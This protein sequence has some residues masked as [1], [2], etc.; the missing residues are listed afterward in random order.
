[1]STT[2][3]RRRELR[4]G[5][6]G[7]HAR[8]RALAA[9]LSVVALTLGAPGAA[10]IGAT[11]LAGPAAAATGPTL[12]NVAQLAE[13]P[14][15]GGT[16]SDQKCPTGDVMVGLSGQT[17]KAV[18]NTI[19]ITD[20][21]TSC[22]PM[23]VSGGAVAPG[24]P[25]MQVGPAIGAAGNNGNFNAVCPSPKV[26]VGFEVWSDSSGS[27]AGVHGYQISC[28]AL[29]ATGVPVG[30][31][32]TV[33]AGVQ[34]GTDSTAQMCPPVSGAGAP[35]GVGA[36]YAGA[37][38]SNGR[39]AG[40]S[41]WCGVIQV[42][43]DAPVLAAIVP[44]SPGNVTTPSVKGTAPAGTTVSVYTN[45]T[46]A[47]TA[48]A[49]GSAS[50]LSTGIA[51]TVPANATTALSAKATANGVD[52]VC[53][54]SL[55]YLE[56]SVAPSISGAPTTAPN[57]AGWYHSDVAIHWTCSDSGSGVATCPTNSTITGEGSNLSTVGTTT[58]NAGNS[59]SS[60]VSGIKID[61]TPPTT[62]ATIAG[63]EPSGWYNTLPLS[64]TLSGT[65]NLSGVSEIQYSLDGVAGAISGSGG[66]VEISSSGHHTLSMSA[67]D[68]AGNVEASHQVSIDVDTDAPA[69]AASLDPAPVGVWNRT[70]VTVSM[71]CADHALADG[72]AG[73]GVATC[74]LGASSTTTDNLD[75]SKTSSTSITDEGRFGLAGSAS[76][77]AGNTSSLSVTANVDMTPPVVM[78]APTGTIG[79]NG[80]YTAPVTVSFSCADP[81]L[82]DQS[83]GS[84]VV[85]CPTAVTLNNDGK[86]QQATSG[87]S[88]DLA[89]N[90]S[91]SSLDGI[92]IDQTGPTVAVTYNGSAT[93]QGWYNGPVTVHFACAD[94]TSGVAGCPDDVTFTS[95][96][97][98]HSASVVAT[99]NAGNET[100]VTVNGVNIDL[101]A[102]SISG[103]ATPAPNGNG[104]NN[105][106]V[107]INWTCLDP[108]LQDGADGSGLSTSCPAPQTVSSEGA[109]QT[110][111]HTVT[112]VAGNTSAPA[113][114]T[115]RL[116]KTAPTLAGAPAAPPDGANGWYVSP[117]TIHWTTSDTLSG[118]DPST[119][120]ADSTLTSDGEGV[121]ASAT[122]S[123]LAGNSTTGD[124]TPVNI[125]Q[126]PPSTAVAAAP[127]A[128]S[129]GT[130][131]I[132]LVATDAT[133]GVAATYYSVDG[134]AN[135]T[136][137][138]VTIDTEGRHHLAFHS[139]DVAGNVEAANSVEVDID[140]SAPTVTPSQLPAANSAGWNNSPVTVTFSCADPALAD[141]SAGSG[142]AS[143]T[144]NPAGSS[145]IAADSQSGTAAVTIGTEGANQN[146]DGSATDNAGN[147]GT[148]HT[149]VSIDRTAPTIGGSA[150]SAPNGHG[151]YNSPVTVTF[152]CSDP[153]GGNGTPGSGIATCDNQQTLSADGAN[154]SVTGNAAD[155]AGNTA[156]ATVHGLNL[157]QTAPSIT[158]SLTPSAPNGSNGWYISPVTVHFSVSDALSGIDP[159]TVPA[160]QTLSTDGANQEATA[161]VSDLAGNVA[162]GKTG[163]VINIDQT[164]PTVTFS[165]SVTAPNANGWYNQAVTVSFTCTDA[166]SGVADCPAAQVLGNGT[167]AAQTVTVY[168]RAGNSTSVTV[169]EIDVDSVAP[170]ITFSGNAGVYTVDQT[171]AINCLATDALSGIDVSRTTCPSVNAPA[172]TLLVGQ[173]NV[174]QASATDL[175]G[176]TTSASTS[177]TVGV[178]CTSLS[179]LVRTFTSDAAVANGLLAKVSAI[180]SSP[181]A[182]SKAGQI[183]AFDNQVRA[184]TGKALTAA[185]ADY[186]TRFAGLL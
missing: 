84:G 49:S 158:P 9:F 41:L 116:D 150:T 135:Q 152:I 106:D 77:E 32:T 43:I 111:T 51:V 182:N 107:T 176:N 94:A 129:N 78:A 109:Q 37:G 170:V 147:T 39:T 162:A 31:I 139:V 175:A 99:D 161:T 169:P 83:A 144:S 17:Q 167:H 151:W 168:D 34:V 185:H 101:T 11:T 128:W 62:I 145:D 93:K 133:S 74:S 173:N 68:A 15:N 27:G 88:Y 48:A 18:G 125:D 6:V 36:G 126:T 64:V 1:M 164:A 28:S 5:R 112:D 160:D 22:A 16:L 179:S 131:T 146:V 148:G 19:W 149:S 104:W 46:C 7:R 29:N 72:S 96:G 75:G 124:S 10:L 76:D 154:Q 102:P 2:H 118:V 114:V 69:L 14:S 55:S 156:A 71:T 143:C 12:A 73:S 121:T 166:T 21:V 100:P 38:N 70:P 184:Q 132:Q 4:R 91:T 85:S 67:T 153:A 42:S 115:V 98:N 45:A 87:P 171:V 60:T 23:T 33:L 178:S 82:A 50:A 26:V 65:D 40:V 54:N 30:A 174:L 13:F 142:L 140:E 86:N 89:G 3:R 47:G 180:C 108:T 90:S 44:A 66:S 25:I 92:D 141:L 181:N 79:G 155:V 24:T 35:G 177:F 8:P 137:T 172:Y 58:D 127:P 59:A 120:P 52:S 61:R 97:A 56:D 130:V 53:S 20:V 117:V 57:G 136:G 134:G 138:T 95:E 110:F 183:G 122:V 159:A 81:D 105:T 119:Q 80:W 165:Q 103:Q 157:D 186:L 163:K 63:N 113:T 123:D